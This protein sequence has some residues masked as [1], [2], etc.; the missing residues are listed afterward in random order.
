LAEFEKEAAMARLL[1]FCCCSSL[2]TMVLVSGGRAPVGRADQMPR[3]P[4]VDGGRARPSNPVGVLFKALSQCRRG[5]PERER[6]RIAGVIHRESQRYGYD[7]LFVVALAAVESTCLPA[8]RSRHGALGL[9]QVRPSVARAVAQDVGLRWRGAD[10]LTKP[11]FNVHIGL[12]YLVQLEK[13]FGDP[14]L[15]VAAYNLGPQRV[16]RMPR[17]QARAT[18]YVQKVLSR[19][20]ALL[21]QHGRG[22]GRADS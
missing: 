9:I 21:A 5:L 1:T 10:M 18:E 8:A 14:Y 22:V 2:I 13:R 11:L 17:H 15:A 20:E 16:A 4:R 6:W 3:P 12:R 7:P 19:Y